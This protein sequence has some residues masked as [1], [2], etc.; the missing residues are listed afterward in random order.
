MLTSVQLFRT[1]APINSLFIA[2]VVLLLNIWGGKRAGTSS[3]YAQ[4]MSEVHKA[5]RMLKSVG[6]R[7]ILL[8]SKLLIIVTHT[9]ELDASQQGACGKHE[10]V[11]WRVSIC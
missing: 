3:E 11:L 6:R 2:G 4:E 5:M 8:T 9:R 10:F 1:C 7:S